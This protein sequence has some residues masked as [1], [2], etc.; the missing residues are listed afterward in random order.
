MN[1]KS[2]IISDEELLKQ[3]CEGNTLA[4]ENLYSR[5]YAKLLYF[6]TQMLGD[7]EN[8]KDTLQEV[9]I[10]LVENKCRF[11]FNRKFSVWIYSIASNMC[12][13][14]FKHKAVVKKAEIEILHTHTKIEE[15]NTT[16]N[17][18][19][20]AIRNAIKNLDTKH[21]QVFILRHSFSFSFKEIANILEISEGTV[22]SRMFNCI[23]KISE[24]KEIQEVK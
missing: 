9:F 21:K 18:K 17:E 19:K 11:D 13:N 15:T 16:T 4:F 22:K 2:I 3:F 23:K 10:K 1:K 7:T 5:Y 6:I 12:K 20:T 8:A 24:Q 14:S